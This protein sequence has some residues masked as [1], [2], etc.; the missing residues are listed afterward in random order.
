MKKTNKSIAGTNFNGVTFHC[1]PNFLIELS[2][3]LGA[4]YNKFNNGQN[5]T[6]FDFTFENSKGD[7]FTVYDWKYYH[8]LNLNEVYEFNIGAKNREKANIAFLDLYTE[9]Q[10][11]EKYYKLD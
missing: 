2:N 11:N 7:V 9:L 1:S 8:K 4:N 3:K 5:K 10:K 6:N